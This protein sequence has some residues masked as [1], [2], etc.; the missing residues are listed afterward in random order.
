MLR[1]TPRRATLND[2]TSNVKF[3]PFA[4]LDIVEMQQVKRIKA[5]SVV[6]LAYEHIREMVE[7]G[8]LE[9]GARLGQ[10]ELADAFGISRTTVREA[11]HRLAGESSSSSRPTAGSSSRRSAST[12]S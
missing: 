4:I 1:V 10:G 9:P 11:L 6:D 3:V 12:R 8:E 2:R 7:D 5:D